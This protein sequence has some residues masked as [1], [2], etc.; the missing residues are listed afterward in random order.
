MVVAARGGLALIVTAFLAAMVVST[1][2]AQRA[3]HRLAADDSVF[4]LDGKPF[5]IISGEMH[6]ARIPREYWHDRLRKARAM[7]LNTISTY[8]FWNLH[9][10]TPGHFEFSGRHDIAAYVR[11]GTPRRQSATR[12][13]AIPEVHPLQAPLM[14]PDPTPLQH[15]KWMATR[16]AT[17]FPEWCATR[18]RSS[19]RA[20]SSTS[21]FARGE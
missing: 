15:P 18:R 8:V 19:V 1:A 21:R 17:W 5:Q 4:L 10:L 14:R 2:N 9:E 11:A 7:G 6:Y 12:P 3:A 16:M 20:R 13:L